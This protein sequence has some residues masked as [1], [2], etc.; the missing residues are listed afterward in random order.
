VN[1]VTPVTNLN[2]EKGF[3]VYPNPLVKGND[4]QLEF[5]NR[6]AGKYTVTLFTIAG[7]RVQQDIVAHAG[8]TAVQSLKLSSQLSSGTYIAEISGVGGVSE[9]VKVVVE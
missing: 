8:G 9:K 7:V 6:V 4:M 2:G 5:R 3:S 1:T